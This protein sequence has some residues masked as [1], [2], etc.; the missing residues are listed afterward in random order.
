MVGE[1]GGYGGGLIRW[2]GEAVAESA[3]GVD[4][5]FA[6]FL[7]CG[8]AGARNDLGCAYGGDVRAAQIKSQPSSRTKR[9]N[10]LIRHCT[11]HVAGKDGLNV[12]EPPELYV[13]PAHLALVQH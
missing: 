7:R 12:P 5:G 1:V 13:P 4:D 2:L 11:Y 10:L 9:I 3:A 6:S 8:D